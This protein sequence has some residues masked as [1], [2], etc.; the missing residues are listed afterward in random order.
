M[1]K[2][3]TAL[4]TVVPWCSTALKLIEFGL[5]C[6]LTREFCPGPRPLFGTDSASWNQST[7]STEVPLH[8]NFLH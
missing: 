7:A 8:L 1:R 6:V 5:G 4:S 2:M 3:K